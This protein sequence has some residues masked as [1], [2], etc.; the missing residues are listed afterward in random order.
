MPERLCPLRR[1]GGGD[2]TR[3]VGWGDRARTRD[4]DDKALEPP[5]LAAE[6]LAL[7]LEVNHATL[8]ILRTAL[9]RGLALLLLRAEAGRCSRVAPPLVLRGG[10]RLPGG[11]IIVVEI[12]VRGN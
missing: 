4:A 11:D 1:R 6:R 5:V 12:L 2:R 10:E 9:E 7:T 3:E 8:K